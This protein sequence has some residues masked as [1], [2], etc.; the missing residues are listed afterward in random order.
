MKDGKIWGKDPLI[1]DS[2][3][4]LAPFITELEPDTLHL[5]IINLGILNVYNPGIWRDIETS[6]LTNTHK[7]LPTSQI[8]PIC[9][10]LD[11]ARRKNN[12]IWTLLAHKINSEIYSVGQLD[13]KDLTKLFK[14]IVMS[15]QENDELMINIINNLREVVH[16]L[17]PREVFGTL[18]NFSYSR[19]RDMDIINLLIDKAFEIIS[20]SERKSYVNLL[21]YTLRFGNSQNLDK[22]ENHAR[23]CFTDVNFG[24]LA[25]LI[26]SY[27][28]DDLIAE[29][30]R[31]AFVE[32]LLKFYETNK[33]TLKIGVADSLLM[34]YEAKILLTTLRYNMP[35]S[36]NEAVRIFNT[37]QN[38]D[39]DTIFFKN[40][41][42]NLEN[43]L[44]SK[45]MI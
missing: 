5:L 27:N 35:V 21:K 4:K 43:E 12:E 8:V 15:G 28:K 44:K 13:S 22:V 45:Q 19:T 42:L 29:P 33:N 38:F 40:V 23:E 24:Q 30:K 39:G 32:F 36:K 31:V 14:A 41:K 7:Y 20:N 16:N 10:A 25:S 3:R 37:F 18:E 34:L 11:K 6:F 26:L 2:V 17:T 1:Q 9:E